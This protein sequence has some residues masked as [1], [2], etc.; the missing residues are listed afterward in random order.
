MRAGL[1][2][3]RSL[4]SPSTARGA[5]TA[6]RLQG[7]KD[8]TGED[9]VRSGVNARLWRNERLV[10]LRMHYSATAYKPPRRALQLAA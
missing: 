8:S 5:T 9:Q 3:T 4:S 1:M 7:P 10:S 6:P 2:K